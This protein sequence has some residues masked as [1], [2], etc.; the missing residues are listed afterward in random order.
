MQ[1]CPD[2]ALPP[3][4]VLTLFAPV[5]ALT[6]LLDIRALHALLAPDP[7]IRPPV[8]E[9]P[10]LALEDVASPAPVK[11]LRPV[12]PLISALLTWGLDKEMDARCKEG[13]GLIASRDGGVGVG[14]RG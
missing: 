10:A 2:R 13:L 7:K 8:V 1:V 4:S 12:V 3:G 14:L 11:T 6:I 5:K 9:D